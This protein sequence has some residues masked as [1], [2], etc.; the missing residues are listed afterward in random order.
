MSRPPPQLRPTPE[1]VTSR[2]G[3][4]SSAEAPA[5]HLPPAL[6]PPAEEVSASP[7]LLKKGE[8]ARVAAS[9]RG[10]LPPAPAGRPTP[11]WANISLPFSK[12]RRAV[13]QLLEVGDAQVLRRREAAGRTQ[14]AWEPTRPLP[15]RTPLNSAHSPQSADE[16]IDGTLGVQGDDVPDVEETGHLA[17]GCGPPGSRGGRGA[18]GRAARLGAEGREDQ[19][20][21]ERRAPN[22]EPGAQRGRGGLAAR[23]AEGGAARP[24]SRCWCP[25]EE[26][27]ASRRTAARQPGRPARAYLRR[28][29]A[30]SLGPPHTHANL[31]REAGKPHPA[32]RTPPRPARRHP[33][34]PARLQRPWRVPGRAARP[35]RLRGFPGQSPSSGECPAGLANPPS[36]G[37]PAVA[38]ALR[39]RSFHTLRVGPRVA[40]SRRRRPGK[41]DSTTSRARG[42]CSEAPRPRSPSGHCAVS[43]PS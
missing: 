32:P 27:P 40:E 23:G 43:A 17:H 36:T 11:T 30:G 37:G 16:A 4:L 22:S 25:G 13:P 42:L 33:R 15:A 39:P 3:C 38:G 24:G 12:R 21:R 19:G 31:A 1:L 18:Q 26:V 35:A 41:G 14:L 7:P 8:R 29:R 34:A 9:R 10:R 28:K 20:G 6:G 5:T 2:P